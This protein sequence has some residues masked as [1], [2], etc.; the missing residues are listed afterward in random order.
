[1]IPHQSYCSKICKLFSTLGP[2][3]IESWDLTD[4]MSHVKVGKEKKR[5]A[6]DV[7]FVGYISCDFI[8]INNNKKKFVTFNK[9]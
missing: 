7:P 1:M 4:F 6:L 8:K 9:Q 2:W 5:N 3:E